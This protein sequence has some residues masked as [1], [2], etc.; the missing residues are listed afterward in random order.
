MNNLYTIYFSKLSHAKCMRDLSIIVAFSRDHAI[1]AVSNF[2]FNV[3]IVL[4]YS[5]DAAL[6]YCF[7]FR[8]L[9]SR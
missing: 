9:L 3:N 7:N 1:I 5:N 2:S 8:S 6:L 4:F